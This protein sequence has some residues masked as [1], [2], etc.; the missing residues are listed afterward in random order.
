MKGTNS[1][2][3]LKRT[4]FSNCCLVV[5]A[6]ASVTV[7]SSCFHTDQ[8]IG[9][10]LCA[11]VSGAGTSLTMQDCTIDST[12][13]GVHA[14]EGATLHADHLQCVGANWVA[15]QANGHGTLLSVSN[16]TLRDTAATYSEEAASGWRSLRPP[17]EKSTGI[18]A[19]HSCTLH[20][21]GTK[22]S[23]FCLGCAARGARVQLQQTSLEWCLERGCHIDSCPAA[24][25]ER[26]TFK[27]TQNRSSLLVSWQSACKAEGS[28]SVV[29]CSFH[30]N[31]AYG[32]SAESTHMHVSDCDFY[33]NR[34][35]VGVVRGSGTFI[36]LRDCRSYGSSRWIHATGAGT[37][38]RVER[39]VVAACKKGVALL[40]HAELQVTDSSIALVDTVLAHIAH[41]AKACLRNCHMVGTPTESMAIFVDQAACLRAVHCQFDKAVLCV[42]GSSSCA[43]LEGCSLT[44]AGTDDDMPV[45]Q[46]A[47][48]GRLALVR[49]IVRG[50]KT[51]VHV[52]DVGT[53]LI[54][55][56]TLFT[57]MADSG[58]SGWEG[59]R[60]ELHDCVVQDCACC[61][62]GV[63]N[64]GTEVLMT[65]GLIE[66]C[67]GCGIVCTDA[68][69]EMSGLL[70]RNV[71]LAFVV[72][73][74]GC[75]Y[76]SECSS[77][78]CVPYSIAGAGRMFCCRCSPE[79][80]S[81]PCQPL[82]C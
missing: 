35:D 1:H 73:G 3:R 64:A 4:T 10:G 32:I 14:T 75:M 6:G 29:A 50:C 74:S 72:D 38:L 11:Y 77:E 62:V 63:C 53:A 39:A 34:K 9:I 69:A 55:Q 49:C 7:H 31:L 17:S 40:D 52:G 67:G 18:I 13:H 54:A 81:I 78:A 82:P 41:S 79:D 80:K 61:A 70:V 36:H 59:A 48:R 26:C 5:L 43:E 45:L 68:V 21:A 20:V 65:G 27:N 22:V 76:L 19:T 58:V 44:S 25:I 71:Q 30:D 8:D 16:S 2:V 47:D 66:N 24:Q 15:L 57:G 33:R 12:C 37:T 46:A 23:G 56:D 51:G 28:T 42:H 60:L